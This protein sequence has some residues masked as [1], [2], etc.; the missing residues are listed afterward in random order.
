MDL[1]SLNDVLNANRTVLLT[2]L[3]WGVPLVTLLLLFKPCGPEGGRLKL[4]LFVAAVAVFAWAECHLGVD[5]VAREG[6]QDVFR[7]AGAGILYFVVGGVSTAAVL[8]SFRS[9]RV[10]L[11]LL[12]PFVM[13]GGIIALIAVGMLAAFLVFIGFLVCLLVWIVTVVLL[14]G[15]SPPRVPRERVVERREVK[16][17]VKIRDRPC[18]KPEE[19]KPCEIPPPPPCPEEEE[20]DGKKKE[21]IKSTSE[22]VIAL[23]LKGARG[24]RVITPEHTPFRMSRGTYAEL[25]EGGERA[26]F[27]QFELRAG[28]NGSS[29]MLLPMPGCSHTV[30]MNGRPVE[31]GV[32]LLA[33]QTI[34]LAVPS[35]EEEGLAEEFGHLEVSFKILLKTTRAKSASGSGKR[36]GKKK[37]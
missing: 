19:C 5:A 25:A 33:G 26:D 21:K 17:V 7:L 22:P 32:F 31:S 12:V 23:C 9:V 27:F 36:S 30:F 20:E 8:L 35:G 18:P 15:C 37:D 10:L 34:S 3:W 6:A 2:G 16:E 29:W 24:S 13:L 1:S 14:L 28:G 11:L 4:R